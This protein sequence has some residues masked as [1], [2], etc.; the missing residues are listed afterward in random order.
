MD[1]KEVDARL[2][3]RDCI[4]IVSPCV[5]KLAGPGGGG[6]WAARG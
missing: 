2:R 1:G 5:C 4:G 6:E 3:D